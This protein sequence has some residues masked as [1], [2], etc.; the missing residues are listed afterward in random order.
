MKE[1]KYL[2]AQFNE[3]IHAIGIDYGVVFISIF[4]VIFLYIDPV[5]KVIIMIVVWY[6]MNIVPSFFKKGITL[7]K[8]NS[9]T[10]VV[11]EFNNEVTLKVMHLRELFKLVIGFIT[12]GLYFLLAL[13][14]LTKRSDKRSIHDFVFKTRVVYKKS[15]ISG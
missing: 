5:F 10:I 8:L 12:L 9:G 4:I 2:P 15:R 13:Y 7:G 11:D 3:R 6:L 14:L 1:D